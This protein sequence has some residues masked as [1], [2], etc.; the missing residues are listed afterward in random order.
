MATIRKKIEITADKVILPPGQNV[1]HVSTSIQIATDVK[2]EDKDIVHQRL[3]D[4]NSLYK[5][6]VEL[7][8][9]TTKAYYARVRYHYTINGAA[10]DGSWTRAV[11]LDQVPGSVNMSAYIV[12]TPKI[13][14]NY[15]ASLNQLDIQTSDFNMFAGVALHASSNFKIT[16]SDNN[17]V[18]VRM[19][20]IKITY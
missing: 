6:I 13:F 20:M 4:Q 15:L 10:K 18:F 5:Y 19:L 14:T 1:K 16:D 8:L 12:S 11:L 7:E 17:N 2:F 9:D 3:K